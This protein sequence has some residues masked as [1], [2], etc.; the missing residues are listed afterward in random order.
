MYR[1]KQAN[2]D[3]CG[4]HSAVREVPVQQTVAEPAHSRK[5]TSR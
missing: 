3:F 4:I 1:P 2:G 5:Y